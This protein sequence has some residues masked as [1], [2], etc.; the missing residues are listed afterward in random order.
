MAEGFLDHIM[1]QLEDRYIML[2][3]SDLHIL[4][5]HM[6]LHSFKK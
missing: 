1:S 3:S 4:Y 5:L 2:V 6:A